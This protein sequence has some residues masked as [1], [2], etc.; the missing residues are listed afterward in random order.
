MREQNNFFILRHFGYPMLLA[1]II[2]S[3][4]I[5]RIPIVHAQ[6]TKDSMLVYKSPTCGCCTSWLNHM[7]SAGFNT[8]IKDSKNLNAIKDRLGITPKNQA[9]HSAIFQGYVFEGHIPSNVIQNF[10]MNRPSNVI[11]LAVPAMPVGSPGMD[12]AEA[13]SPYHVLLLKK[14]GSSEKYAKVSSNNISYL[15]AK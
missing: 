13:F 10:L 9:C 8:L 3:T 2:L 15:G 12:T 6:T 4:S 1:I 7:K 11:G 5:F 14:D